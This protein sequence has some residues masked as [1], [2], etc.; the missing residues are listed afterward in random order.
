MLL[1]NEKP[2]AIQVRQLLRIPLTLN[3][4]Y[5]LLISISSYFCHADEFAASLLIGHHRAIGTK[6]LHIQN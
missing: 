6:F 5:P 4:Y 3:K 1:T 2:T